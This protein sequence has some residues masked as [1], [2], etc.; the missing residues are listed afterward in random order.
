VLD[1]QITSAVDSLS[2]PLFSRLSILAG[3]HALY[4]LIATS[5]ETRSDSDIFISHIFAANAD[6]PSVHRRFGRSPHGLLTRYDRVNEAL[7]DAADPLL[8]ALFAGDEIDQST[9]IRF[10]VQLH[11]TCPR[12]TLCA[13]PFIVERVQTLLGGSNNGFKEACGRCIRAIAG[14]QTAALSPFVANGSLTDALAGIVGRR[15]P[16]S[17]DE[18]SGHERFCQCVGI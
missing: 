18:D 4:S 2:L 11:R 9:A 17:D 10:F 3:V 7:F 13:V 5:S 16:F 8:T 14:W 15:H 6:G 1:E 12:R